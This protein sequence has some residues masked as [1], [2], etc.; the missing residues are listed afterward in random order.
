MR[1]VVYMMD[2]TDDPNEEHPFFKIQSIGTRFI[3]VFTEAFPKT[4]FVFYRESVQVMMSHLDH[5]HIEQSNCVRPRNNPPKIVVDLVERH[6][7]S[8]TELSHEEYCAAHLASI[9]DSAL[10]EMK[11]SS[12]ES[13]GWPVNYEDLPDKL[14]DVIPQHFGVPL[15]QTERNRIAKISGVYSKGRGNR[16]H[17]WKDDSEQK[18]ERATDAIKGACKMFLDE[19]FEGLEE[20]AAAFNAVGGNEGLADET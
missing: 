4:P 10:K 18:E 20:R 8:V 16:A 11:C 9:C 3:D 14:Y 15:S 5:D 12:R 17:E 19:T 13:L 6:G 7:R 1:D 2:R